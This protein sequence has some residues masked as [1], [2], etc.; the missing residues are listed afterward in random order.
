[1]RHI[2]NTDSAELITILHGRY[3][4]LTIMD[5]QPLVR[6][7]EREL[8]PQKICIGSQTCKQI[9]SHARLSGE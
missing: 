1:M 7:Y 5:W 4:Q 6:N 3:N 8:H 2:W 9:P